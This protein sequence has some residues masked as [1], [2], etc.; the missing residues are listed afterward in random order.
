[1]DRA[2]QEVS[3]IF[4]VW[5]YYNPVKI[6]F[7][8]NI[9][10]NIRPLLPSGRA[11]VV[12]G[13]NATKKLFESFKQHQ[14]GIDFTLFDCVEPN[15]SAQRVE[16][17]I[18]LCEREKCDWVLGLG[19]GSPLD[20]AKIIAFLAGKNTSVLDAMY[21]RKSV[22]GR[23][24]PFVAV[25][26]TA[27]SGSEV[28]PYSIITDVEDKKK[29]SIAQSDSY[30][31]IA[32]VDPALTMGLPPSITAS[33]GLDVLAHAIE[34]AWSKT[35][36]EIST[37]YALEAMRLV[38]AHL[39]VAVEDGN[40]REAREKMMLASLYA[41]MAISNTGTTVNHPISYPLTLRRNLAHGFACAISLPATMRYN[42]LCAHGVLLRMARACQLGTVEEL[43]QAVS[44][45]LK[46]VGAPLTLS[47][48]NIGQNDLDW[49][50]EESYGKN[51]ARNPAP[52]EKKDLYNMLKEML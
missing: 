35:A 40:N 25:P 12:T 26:T 23:G 4:I 9:S 16:E 51:F 50:T 18:A 5:S 7:G 6:H 52:M 42:R 10:Q 27:G 36:N 8:W 48:L 21:K 24:L 29:I 3:G 20:C 49:L 1:V 22:Q 34:S 46:K 19:G 37:F 31:L 43:I 38:L 11:L 13:A 33:T 2:E 44:D 32:F 39:P 30:P 17:G 41:G 14:K 45:L 15:P 28:T 47:S